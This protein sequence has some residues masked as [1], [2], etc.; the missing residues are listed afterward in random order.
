MGCRF[1]GSW[2]KAAL[3]ACA[4]TATMEEPMTPAIGPALATGLRHTQIAMAAEHDLTLVGRHAGSWL[5]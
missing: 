4:F 3:A 2:G 5:A 1:P